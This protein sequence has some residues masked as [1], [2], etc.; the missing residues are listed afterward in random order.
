MKD[1]QI[2]RTEIAF[3]HLLN[4][5][6]GSGKPPVVVETPTRVFPAEVRSVLFLRQDRIGDAIITTPLLKFVKDAFP[7]VSVGVL[8][9]ENNFAVKQA[10]H[11]YADHTHMYSK[12]LCSI[13]SLRKELR[14][15][16][17]DIAVD[18]MD[19]P[20]VTSALL[21]ELAGTK[22][23]I[24][25]DKQNR[26]IY[27]HVVPLLDRDTVHI[28]HRI[29][30]LL[31]PFGLDPAGL[32]MRP[33]YPVSD[34]EMQQAY[35]DLNL[36]P[37]RPVIGVNVS[38]G[39]VSRWFDYGLT[40]MIIE[41]LHSRCPAAHLILFSDRPLIGM[42]AELGTAY[43]YVQVAPLANSFHTFAT[44]MSLMN[45]IITP[46]TSIVHVAAAHNI[47]TVCFFLRPKGAPLPWTPIDTPHWYACATQPP[48]TSLH[49]QTVL[50]AVEGML[51]FIDL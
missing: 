9:G 45:A 46:D 5:I 33:L 10:F 32:S 2:K 48:I 49:K 30:Q 22:F 16:R 34:I 24:G 26:G 11:E 17:Y 41:Y 18:C 14:Q 35:A 43:P 21:L 47:P 28:S 4:S 29:A 1:S 38:G 37:S 36:S 44:R 8:L 40:A 7:N 12:R 20:S 3:R 27:S 25:I 31:I 19:N 50:D 15:I 13:V 39:T 42:I 6:L 51:A 23:R